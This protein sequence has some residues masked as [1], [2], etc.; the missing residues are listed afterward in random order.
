MGPVVCKPI[1]APLLEMGTVWGSPRFRQSQGRGHGRGSFSVRIVLLSAIL[2]SLAGCAGKIIQGKPDLSEQSQGC[3][4]TH[5]LAQMGAPCLGG[6]APPAGRCAQPA[7]PQRRELASAVR[8]PSFG[9]SLAPVL[10]SGPSS[11]S[12]DSQL[13]LLCK[14]EYCGE[15]GRTGL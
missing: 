9:C 15:E 8:S 1:C 12:E 11:F 6:K 14:E 4:P 2:M 7:A 13:T 5:S 3:L 10:G